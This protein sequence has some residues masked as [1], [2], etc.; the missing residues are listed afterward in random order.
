MQITLYL[1]S[2][3]SKILRLPLSNLHLFQSLLYKLLPSEHADFLHNK[4]YVVDGHPMKLFAMSWPISPAHPKI[5]QDGIEMTL[6]IRLVV[7][8]PVSATLNGIAGGALMNEDL[9]IGNNSVYCEHVEGCENVVDS[10]KI[11]VRT[12]S[13]ITCYSQMTRQDGRKYTAYFS[14]FEKDFAESI[15]NNLVRKFKALHPQKAVPDKIVKI[16]SVGTPK[17]RIAKFMDKN[18]FPIKGWAGIFTLTG[19]QELLQVG[20]D[21]GLGAKNSGGWG[22]VELIK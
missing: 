7:S 12:L 14:P 17:E 18:P 9:H 16:V 20:V 10:N 3:D 22:C 21:C 8:T 5:T 19:P 6:P 11:T 4:G 15:H 13:P 2:R 1:D